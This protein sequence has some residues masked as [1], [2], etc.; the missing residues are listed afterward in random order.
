MPPLESDGADALGEGMTERVRKW[1]S[2]GE[3][4]GRPVLTNLTAIGCF[5]PCLSELFF[6]FSWQI[7]QGL[8]GN[9]AVLF[10][11][12]GHRDGSSSWTGSAFP[13]AISC[14]NSPLL[15]LGKSRILEQILV[16]RSWRGRYWKIQPYVIFPG[17]DR[18][19]FHTEKL[20]KLLKI[21]FKWWIT[22]ISEENLK[23]DI[24]LFF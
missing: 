9:K 12:R 6:K 19:S 10:H 13:G 15:P 1:E 17:C 11:G 16:A 20:F 5:T 22:F 8:V 4:Q 23:L 14:S 7:S 3:I 18:F 21:F 2:L 24:S